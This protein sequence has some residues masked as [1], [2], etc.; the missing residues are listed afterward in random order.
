MKATGLLFAFVDFL[1]FCLNFVIGTQHGRSLYSL[2]SSW[3]Q[4]SLLAAIALFL[5]SAF[6]APLRWLQPLVALV[7][8]PV[9]V[10]TGPRHIY[11][12]GFFVVGVALLERAG[13][14]RKNRRPKIIL[15]AAYFLAQELAAAF[16]GH[17]SLFE[18]LSPT[19][20]TV[21]FGLLLW[22]LYRDRLLVFLREPKPKL[23]LTEK[24][25]SPAEKTY[26]LALIEGKA[27]KEICLD[28]EVSE[29]TVRNSLSRAYKKLGV[30][31][32]PELM[33]LAGKYEVV[34]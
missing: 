6:I 13:F 18:A 21:A 10:I 8:G 14:F 4:I 27:A 3:T 31:G 24:G 1:G 20:F 34:A 5:L 19:L 7:L 32:H 11:G 12:L 28:Y 9:A 33:S 22:Y 15:V 26:I 2:F 25:L 23:S 16:I 17:Q 29:S 30:E